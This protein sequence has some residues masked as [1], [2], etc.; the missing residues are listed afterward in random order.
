MR[1]H[2]GRVALVTGGASGIGR[3]CSILLAAQGATVAVAAIDQRDADSVVQEITTAGGQAFGL[4]ADVTDTVAVEAAVQEIISRHGRLDIVVTSAGVQ[5]Y[6]SVTA[7]TDAIWDE[8]FATNVKGVFL[9]VRAAMPYLRTS[10]HGAVVIIS[11][12]QALV[13]QTDVVAYTASK[14]ALNALARAVAVDEARHNVRVN[15]VCPGSI[16]T[17]MLRASAA[18]FSASPATADDTIR[19]WGASHPLGRVGQPVEV[20]EAVSFLAG[21]QASFITGAEIVV[22]GGLL[23]TLPVSIPAPTTGA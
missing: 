22:D 3:A 19:A 23:A 1:I 5:R 2:E 16:D 7:T 20:A 15:V 13:T 12:V 4:V 9:V 17:P 6:G 21:P 14:G 8:V 11:S 10:G 18:L